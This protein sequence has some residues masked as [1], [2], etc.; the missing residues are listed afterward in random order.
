MTCFA[1]DR[2]SIFTKDNFVL[3]DGEYFDIYPLETAVE[4][5][6]GFEKEALANAPDIEPRYNTTYHGLVGDREM[7]ENTIM[8]NGLKGYDGCRIE[9]DMETWKTPGHDGNRPASIDELR[10]AL[11]QYLIESQIKPTVTINGESPENYFGSD[12][13]LETRKGRAKAV[14]STGTGEDKR[15]FAKVYVVKNRD[16]TKV[17]DVIVRVD[18]AAMY[19]DKVYALN[20]FDVVVEIEPKMSREVLNSNRDG[21]HAKFNR[22]LSAFKQQ[23]AIDTNSALKDKTGKKHFTVKG[24]HGSIRSSRK[25]LPAVMR[26]TD[27]DFED[28]RPRLA[29]PGDARPNG[30]SFLKEANVTFDVAKAFVRTVRDRES[31]LNAVTY[32]ASVSHEVREKVRTFQQALDASPDASDNPQAAIVDACPPELLP[33]I[34]EAVTERVERARNEVRAEHEKLLSDMHDTVIKIETFND[35]TKSLPRKYD[36]TNWSTETG[37]GKRAHGLLAAWTTAISIVSEALFEVRPALRPFD[38]RVGF[39]FSVAE[40]KW[41]GDDTRPGSTLAE[42]VRSGDGEDVHEFLINP[43]DDAGKM[44]FKL[45]DDSDIWKIIAYA[46]H[47]VA[48][49][50]ESWHDERFAKLVT[51]LTAKVAPVAAIRRVKQNVA[52]TVAA[53]GGKSTVH[54]LDND[55]GPRPADRLRNISNGHQPDPDLDNERSYA[56][57]AI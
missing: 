16:E 12:F 38:W 26:S 3:G 1:M 52:A 45:T 36:P 41:E 34:V 22:E 11:K 43:I 6:K 37:K 56:V 4:T 13:T 23:L 46:I 19:S 57:G 42:H 40:L 55:P 15:D 29:N 33:W 24:E 17:T 50:L 30:I 53:Y 10:R 32:G 44:A 54:A 39:V 48:H 47:E 2:Y 27:A 25:A 51:D 20:G 21:M 31:F 28:I 18:G 49:V 14:L 8:K 5:L 35:K 7:I 9:V